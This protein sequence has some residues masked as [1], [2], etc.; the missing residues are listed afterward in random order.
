MFIITENGCYNPRTMSE[1]SGRNSKDAFEAYIRRGTDWTPVIQL[2]FMDIVPSPEFEIVGQPT[3]TLS[4]FWTEDFVET[5]G[6][7]REIYVPNYDPIE[8]D[9]LHEAMEWVSSNRETFEGAGYDEKAFYPLPPSVLLNYQTLGFHVQVSSD[10]ERQSQIPVAFEVGTDDWKVD[11]H[12][13]TFELQ[14]RLRLNPLELGGRIDPKI[15]STSKTSRDITEFYW[16]GGLKRR[17]EAID[18]LTW[19]LLMRYRLV[20]LRRMRASAAPSEE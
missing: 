15:Y 18:T 1:R 11:V 9:L 12:L 17:E 10:A 19:H 14:D 3:R 13:S 7:I 8:T 20:L 6:L 5:A 16:S 4:H 2:H